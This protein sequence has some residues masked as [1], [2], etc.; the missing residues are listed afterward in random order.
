MAQPEPVVLFFPKGKGIF[1]LGDYLV[2]GPLKIKIDEHLIQSSIFDVKHN[3]NIDF[4]IN[5]KTFMQELVKDS[6]F[7]P[8]DF[9]PIKPQ[10]RKFTVSGPRC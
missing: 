5:Q 10:S 8:Q 1:T 6:V 2:G 9:H 4:S 7:S 3:D